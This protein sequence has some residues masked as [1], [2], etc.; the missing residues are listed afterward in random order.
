LQPPID[1]R[2]DAVNHRMAHVMLPG[3]Q[4]HQLVVPLELFADG[5]AAQI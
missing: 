4:L 2:D 5:G 3:D 1:Q